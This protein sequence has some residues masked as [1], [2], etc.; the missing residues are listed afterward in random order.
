MTDWDIMTQ[1][2]DGSTLNQSILELTPTNVNDAFNKFDDMSEIGEKAIVTLK[3]VCVRVCYSL[4]VC[5][6]VCVYAIACA[7]VC[8]CVL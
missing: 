7:C 1:L 8:V 3:Q 5:V 4:C 2:S 6:C